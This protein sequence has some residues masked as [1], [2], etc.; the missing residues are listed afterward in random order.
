MFG[1][2]FI[3]KKINSFKLRYQLLLSIVLLISFNFMFLMGIITVNLL[4]LTNT[5]YLDFMNVLDNLDL[6]EINSFSSFLDLSLKSYIDDSKTYTNMINSIYNSIDDYDKTMFFLNKEDTSSVINLMDHGINLDSRSNIGYLTYDETNINM[7]DINNKIQNFM[8]LKPSLDYLKQIHISFFE[9]KAVNYL[10]NISCL[11]SNYTFKPPSF[12]ESVILDIPNSNLMFFYPYNNSDNYSSKQEIINKLSS[13]FPIKNSTL[14]NLSYNL[15]SSSIIYSD[16]VIDHTISLKSSLEQKEINLIVESNQSFNQTLFT[17]TSFLNFS[18]YFIFTELNNSFKVINNI[19]YFKFNSTLN[20][21]NENNIEILNNGSNYN[22]NVFNDKNKNKN[23]FLIDELN[24]N[25][26]LNNKS[27]IIENYTYKPLRVNIENN[28]YKV[29]SRLLPSDYETNVFMRLLLMK[30]DKK[31][32]VYK[33]DLYNRSLARLLSSI[34]IILLINYMTIIIIHRNLMSVIKMIDKPML[35]I[36][37]VIQSISETEKFRISKSQ[38][39]DYIVSDDEI[40]EEFIELMSIILSMIQGNN[41]AITKISNS[42]KIKNLTEAREIQRDFYLIKANNLM[43]FENKIKAK[44][45]S[46]SYFKQTQSI[47]INTILKDNSL[48]NSPFFIEICKDYLSQV[49]K[50]K[51]KIENLKEQ[52][53][54]FEN[55]LKLKRF[56]LNFD[57]KVEVT[58]KNSK[59]IKKKIQAIKKQN[60]Y[61]RSSLIERDRFNSDDSSNNKNLY[62]EG[63]DSSESLTNDNEEQF[64][65]PEIISNLLK[66][67]SNPYFS[68]YDL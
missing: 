60:N 21:K 10:K 63:Y 57:E 13:S 30:S 65:F 24:Y 43:I 16:K 40:L 53:E 17:P 33:D 31:N 37:N 41:E 45:I 54:D 2:D 5:L 36:N 46:D 11:Q 35:L 12:Y 61:K 20:T 14:L 4:L 1:F 62:D 27:L 34:S 26:N 38:L 56:E 32:K 55:K 66:D 49:H 48:Q 51:Y 18:S 9:I 52:K 7:T 23:S 29:V 44:L 58:R 25:K 47:D 8:I 64:F 28:F 50:N 42:Q 39:E 3:V 19:E 67:K 68:L 6:E 22:L 59:I 15:N